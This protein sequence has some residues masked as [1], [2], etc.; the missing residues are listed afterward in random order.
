M[1]SKNSIIVVL[2]FLVVWL[3]VTVIR[4]ENYHYANQVG[5]CDKDN[6]VGDF[7]EKETQKSECFNTVETRTNPMWHLY[8]ALTD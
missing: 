4:L 8:Y 3:S 7:V 5:V 6:F 1:S 2:V